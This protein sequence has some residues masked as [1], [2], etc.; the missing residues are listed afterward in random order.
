MA[1]KGGSAIPSGDADSGG[2]FENPVDYGTEQTG[3][4]SPV[5]TPIPQGA[6]DGLSVA[7][8]P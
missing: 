5:W 3:G 2:R 4:A 7:F 8:T 1:R 6:L